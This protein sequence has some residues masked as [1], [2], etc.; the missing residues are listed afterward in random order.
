MGP[1]SLLL[2]SPLLLLSSISDP[3]HFNSQGCIHYVYRSRG[4]G[5]G[6][7]QQRV[8]LGDLKLFGKE[9]GGFAKIG[10]RRVLIFYPLFKKGKRYFVDFFIKEDRPNCSMLE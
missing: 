5:G 8:F 7:G 4:G 9:Q 2:P 6:G 1:M 3:L 10:G